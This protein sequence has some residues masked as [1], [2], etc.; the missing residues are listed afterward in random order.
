MS[1]KEKAVSVTSRVTIKKN[2]FGFD[3][4]VEAAKEG[5]RFVDFLVKNTI[6][7]E[8]KASTDWTKYLLDFYYRELKSTVR[9]RKSLTT[10]ERVNNEK[11]ALRIVKTLGIF[12][13]LNQ[14]SSGSDE[15]T[16]T[17]EPFEN[18]DKEE[19]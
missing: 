18:L 13:L 14:L 17:D 9:K 4:I 8:G 16:E 1:K 10:I 3:P 19:I 5:Q 6:D 11:E 7:K 15:E 2:P 12:D